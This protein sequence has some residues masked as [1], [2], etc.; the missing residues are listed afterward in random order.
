MFILDFLLISLILLAAVVYIT[1]VV[2]LMR[3]VIEEIKER[4]KWKK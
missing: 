4:R 3:Y 2:L 1:G